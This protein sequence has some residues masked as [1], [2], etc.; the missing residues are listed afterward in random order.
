M[1][2]SPNPTPT[3]AAPPRRRQFRPVEVVAVR[4]VTPRLV[5][6]ALGG[7][8]LA[9]FEI[10]APTQ[11]VKILFPAP[12][13]DAPTLPEAGPD[14]PRFPDD[15]PRPVMRTFTPRRFD[16][17]SNTLDVEFVL[18]DEGPASAWARRARVGHRLAVAGPGGRM[19]LVLGPGRWI[20]AGDE[21]AIPAVGTL[22]AALPASASAEVYLEVTDSS[23]QMALDSA[24]DVSASWLHRAP[25]A[26]GTSL[27]TALS[28]ATL[29]GAAGVWVACEAGAVRRIRQALLSGRSLDPS[30]LVTR[31]YWRLGEENHPDHDYGEDAA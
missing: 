6:V 7:D 2:D 28:E 29:T 15:R 17:A 12:G 23:D 16:A 24:A 3:A 30:L 21:S 14:G 11:H 8:T 31:G 26:F 20:V 4:R 5:S 1:A 9:G 22:L 27:E 25:G 19:P 18:H 10:A 13:E